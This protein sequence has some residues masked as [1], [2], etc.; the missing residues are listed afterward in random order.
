MN[1][2]GSKDVYIDKIFGTI[3]ENESN[4]DLLKEVRHD[5]RAFIN[6]L[7]PG[8]NKKVTHT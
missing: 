6:P 4:K 3:K 8:S 2:A 7:M 1:Y 5:L